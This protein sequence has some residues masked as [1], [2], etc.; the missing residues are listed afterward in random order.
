MAPAV[1]SASEL[2]KPRRAELASE[3]GSQN[4]SASEEQT[5]IHSWE[6]LFRNEHKAT[7]HNT[8]GISDH[9]LAVAKHS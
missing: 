2:F 8:V 3:A 4:A 9:W 6:E 7:S 1:G 5:S